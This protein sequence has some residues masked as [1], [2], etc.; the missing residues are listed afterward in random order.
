[1]RV[2]MYA[3]DEHVYIYIYIY[4]C[5]GRAT[6]YTCRCTPTRQ[7]MCSVFA[8]ALLPHSEVLKSPG[9]AGGMR[10]VDMGRQVI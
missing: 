3:H 7:D 9:G 4:I 10:A 6:Q 8:H 2:H 5:I 1:M